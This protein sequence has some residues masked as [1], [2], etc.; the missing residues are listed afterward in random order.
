MFHEAQEADR[1]PHSV[2]CPKNFLNSLTHVRNRLFQKFHDLQEPWIA[3]AQISQREQKTVH[4]PPLP[5]GTSGRPYLCRK[6]DYRCQHL[7]AASYYT[8]VVRHTPDGAVRSAGACCSEQ[9]TL[10]RQ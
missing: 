1:V 7:S 10:S 9:H 2:T 6:E 3:Q 8:P 4:L 5:R